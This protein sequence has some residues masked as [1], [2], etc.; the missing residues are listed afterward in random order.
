MDL[1]IASWLS[2]SH[3]SRAVWH[4]TFWL[5]LLAAVSWS[6]PN[7]QGGAFSGVEETLV[8]LALAAI[9]VYL[10]LYRLLPLLSQQ[11]YLRYAAAVLLLLVL[12]AAVLSG[13]LT[14]FY[15]DD[16]SY[17]QHLVNIG[18]L[19]GISGGLKLYRQDVQRQLTAKEA[20]AQQLQTELSLLVAQVHPHFLFN[21]L[22]NLY[23]L[24]LH[25]P[26][27]AA[28][29]VLKLAGLMRYML[30]QTRGEKTELT[31]EIQFL[32]DYLALER[33]RLPDGA[34]IHFAVE[35]PSQGRLVPMLL[36]PFLENGFKHGINQ[37]AHGPY[38]HG[39]LRTDADTLY[40]YL[41]NN[42]PVHPLPADVTRTATGLDNVRR[43]LA[44]A[45]PG[46]H[47]LTI[48]DQPHTFTVHLAIQL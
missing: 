28:E 37:L 14:R 3:N 5:L 30:T 39:Y 17:V 18:A 20:Q 16:T 19:L 26:A 4:A 6:I 25:E 7:R 9:A 32:Q 15:D 24:T 41:E 33:L 43:R 31:G 1:R 29:V 40:F 48:D 35:G 21:T 10:H 12:G 45:Y 34:D 13:V 36:I 27:R 47:Q 23:G 44:L 11:R 22:N 8:F 2:T 42:K 38:L 46:R